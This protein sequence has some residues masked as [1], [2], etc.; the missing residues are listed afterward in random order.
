MPEQEKQQIL[1]F[2]K[3]EPAN[4]WLFCLKNDESSIHCSMN[5][6]IGAALHTILLLFFSS[7]MV[8]CTAQA[9]YPPLQFIS[10][11]LLLLLPDVYNTSLPVTEPEY[12]VS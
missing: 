5:G 10:N 4:V 6:L 1:T 2:E 12:F 7:P 9:N 3:L 8:A 11:K